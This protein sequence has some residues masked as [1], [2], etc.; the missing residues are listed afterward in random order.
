MNSTVHWIVTMP[1]KY[2]L[3][4]RAAQQE[5]TRRR[6]IDATVALHSTVGPART[7]ISAVAERAG[8]QRLTFYRHFPDE[9]ALLRACSGHYFTT[10]PF[11]DSAP[12]VA[13]ADPVARLRRGLT[14]I[15][16]FF[17]EN[18]AMFSLGARDAPFVPALVETSQPLY[19]YL[20]RARDILAAGWQELDESPS[21]LQAALGHALAFAT[22]QSL[23]REQSI[24]A[25]QA[26]ELMVCFAQCAAGG[27]DIFNEHFRQ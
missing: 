4:K 26:V 19:D 7:T 8:V 1:R 5:A 24:E 11:P 2:E 20:E 25:E 27:V 17:A 16:A 10:H 18:E 9:T 6:I 14:D 12:W 23:V 13:I 22:W 21:L 15:Y 3:K